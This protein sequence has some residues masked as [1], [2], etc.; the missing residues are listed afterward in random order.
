MNGINGM[1]DISTHFEKL[2]SKILA[3]NGYEIYNLYSSHAT[4]GKTFE[5]DFFA[6]NIKNDFIVEV[7][8]Y[9]S[10]KENTALLTRSASMLS[11]KSLALNKK[12]KLLIV[13]CIVSPMIRT[14]IEEVYGITIYDRSDL[15]RLAIISA[16]L[17]DQLEKIFEPSKDEFKTEQVSNLSL[18]FNNLN[19]EKILRAN[20]KYSNKILDESINLKD[21]LE[22]TPHGEGSSYEEICKK[23]LMFIFESQLSGWHTQLST[24]DSLHRY[25][26]VCR[27]KSDTDMWSFVTNEMKSRYVVFEF[28][29]YSNPISQQQILTT[30]KYLFPKSFRSV[31]FIISRMKISKSAEIMCQGAMRENGKLIINLCDNDLVAMINKKVENLEPSDYLFSLV[32]DFL[33]G[34]SR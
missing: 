33:L 8:F 29:N 13:S 1:N 4:P 7:K 12:D 18:E 28:K 25:D 10:E 20:D 11:R 17:T 5:V 26:L 32:D 34:L 16:E 6:K 23:I 27:V 21:E 3:K 31:A 14:S 24:F 19:I 9:R 30:E 22:K 2:C 15:L